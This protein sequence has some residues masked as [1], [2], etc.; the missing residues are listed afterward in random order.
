MFWMPWHELLRSTHCERGQ[1]AAD[2]LIR[3]LAA[4]QHGLVARWQLRTLGVRGHVIDRRVASGA[5][6]PLF[7]GVYAVGHASVT[8]T[9]RHM[10]AVLAAGPDTAVSVRHAGATHALRPTSAARIDVTRA[11]GA[12]QI[13]GVRI[14]LTRRWHP[15]DVVLVDR[16]P[17]T[18]VCR[19]I[20]DLADILTSQGLDSVFAHAE[21][22]QL[23]VSDLDAA[24]T[25]VRGRRGTGPA[26]LREARERLAAYGIVLTRSEGEIL[27]R[28]IL[29]EAGLLEP[30]M[31]FPIDGD[32]L[33]AGWPGLR[34]GIELDSWEFHRGRVRF[35]RDRAKLRRMTLAGWTVLPFSGHDLVHRPQLVTSEAAQLLGSAR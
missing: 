20:V 11:G 19:T 3:E 31:N 18:S 26:R 30:V 7:P 29:G 24:V 12:R 25:R 27:L 16:V 13:P 14:H 2:L 21:R 10:G 8:A 15:D 32:E 1:I 35:V 5:L 6:I 9:G 34:V 4:V 28:E 22:L 23:D 17:V 33:D